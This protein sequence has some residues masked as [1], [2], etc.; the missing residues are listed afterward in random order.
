MFF[1]QMSSRELAEAGVLGLDDYLLPAE[2]DS[3]WEPKS[4]ASVCEVKTSDDLY[5]KMI[6]EADPQVFHSS[7][8]LLTE[9]RQVHA[10]DEMIM[11]ETLKIHIFRQKEKPDEELPRSKIRDS[12]RLSVRKERE[13]FRLQLEKEKLEVDILEKSLENECK[14]KKPKDRSKKVIRCSIME[15][16][17]PEKNGDK[18]EWQEDLPGGS[19]GS[20]DIHAPLLACS[21]S[22][23]EHKT[24]HPEEALDP[25]IPAENAS[26]NHP[27]QL[28]PSQADQL[29]C[30]TSLLRRNT[31]NLKPVQ[32]LECE[33]SENPIKPEASL[34]PELR[35]DDGAFDPGGN[36]CVRSL[37]KPRKVLLAKDEP[38]E[39]ETPRFTE[40]QIPSLSS[41]T[42]DL[43]GET[44]VH[45]RPDEVPESSDINH[46]VILTANEKKHHNNNNQTPAEKYEFP[47]DCF[48]ETNIKDEDH[49]LGVFK[50]LVEGDLQSVEE[51][52]TLSPV[53][54]CLLPEPPF[55]LQLGGGG[56][57]DA[58][59]SG[60]VQTSEWMK[61]SGCESAGGEPQHDIAIRQVICGCLYKLKC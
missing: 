27:I 16:T 57:Q 15:K 59:V 37:P 58:D 61:A 41:L 47:S 11:E 55:E 44:A 31:S 1:L 34:T 6:P 14:V 53:N 39:D 3:V 33:F 7:S 56:H 45:K 28:P 24:E 22:E 18:A 48:S 42:D 51:M 17:R 2:S 25:R 5:N 50:G 54:P 10:L 21:D 29:G 30:E 52:S 8:D 13:A 40:M 49:A 35:P 38:S 32:H 9:L 19:N 60:G 23:L 36:W 20:H 12:N 46:S 4:T 26:T 43:M